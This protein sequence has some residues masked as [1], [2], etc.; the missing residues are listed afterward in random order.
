M[1]GMEVMLLPL[2]IS[3]FGS[4]VKNVF[5]NQDKID[6]FDSQKAQFQKWE[7]SM[8]NHVCTIE[9]EDLPGY[10]DDIK[11]E[12]P[13][14]RA[15]QKMNSKACMRMKTST[16]D[17]SYFQFE[18]GKGNAGIGKMMWM[19]INKE[20][21]AFA[22]M[23]A[24]CSFELTRS[25]TDSIGHYFRVKKLW[26]HSLTTKKGMDQELNEMITLSLQKMLV[27]ELEQ[28]GFLPEGIHL[29]PPTV[30]TIEESSDFMEKRREEIYDPKN[31]EERE[32]IKSMAAGLT[33]GT[34][35]VIK[36]ALLD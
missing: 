24:M 30:K 14:A 2:I 1:T 18:D 29:N 33:E 27:V 11:D 10:I 9:K 32:A 3:G 23:V 26:G 17:M 22:I 5:K 16:V 7:T 25:V 6:G 15:I 12:F 21:F 36:G 4:I 19:R 35:N 13:H 28:K 8:Y 34:L 31:D 20:E